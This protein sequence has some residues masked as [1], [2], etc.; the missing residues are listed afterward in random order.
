MERKRKPDLEKPE[1]Q[2]LRGHNQPVGLINYGQTCYV[3]SLLQILY[4]LPPFVQQI[5]DFP[6]TDIQAI[7][8]RGRDAGKEVEKYE[9][10]VTLISHLKELMGL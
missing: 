1:S 2:R 4:S 3:N 6:V 8:E 9:A 5:L 10:G 7:I